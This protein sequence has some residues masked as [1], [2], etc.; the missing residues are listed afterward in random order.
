MPI[1]PFAAG[2]AIALLGI[3]L[4]LAV[5]SHVSYKR[6]QHKRTLVVL[7]S[8]ASVVCCFIRVLSSVE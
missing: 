1:A 7:G 8:G 5:I 3:R 2:G 6:R 4:V